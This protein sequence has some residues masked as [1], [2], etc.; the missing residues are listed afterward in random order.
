MKTKIQICFMF[1]VLI[2]SSVMGQKKTGA[3][4]LLP[5]DIANLC[6]QYNENIKT[7]V[8]NANALLTNQPRISVEPVSFEFKCDEWN[9]RLVSLNVAQMM[10]PERTAIREILQNHYGASY[11]CENLSEPP[12]ITIE[13]SDQLVKKALRAIEEYKNQAEKYAALTNLALTAGKWNTILGSQNA[14]KNN[15][16]LKDAC[17]QMA[18]I[19]L[20]TYKKKIIEEHD[21]PY[22][23]SIV[24]LYNDLN[25]LA[26][27]DYINE[28][29][30]EL[31][32]LFRFKMEIEIGVYRNSSK[33]RVSSVV[34]G[35]IPLLIDMHRQKEKGSNPLHRFSIPFKGEGLVTASGTASLKHDDGT[36]SKAENMTGEFSRK[37]KVDLN[38]CEFN[39][40][41]LCS[42]P[43][44]G[45]SENWEGQEF[46]VWTL[47]FQR[48]ANG[49]FEYLTSEKYG[50]VSIP[51]EFRFQN[52]QKIIIDDQLVILKNVD[53]SDL[54][55]EVK[56]K[57]VHDSN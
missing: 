31:E 55:L 49:N 3:I 54:K 23:G 48:F 1:F 44:L 56:Y 29:F 26:G 43:Y 39:G 46:Y 15:Q 18:K 13:L 14:E 38:L 40:K 6:E 42:Y 51:I 33:E 9:N 53:G 11:S 20:T 57:I 5:E 36:N 8:N 34:K 17:I 10:E 52:R 27:G 7:T 12:T 45:V 41:F 30:T 22:F 37:A 35:E 28:M 19:N 47:E 32:A 21:Y 2:F 25:I 4:S 24:A 50:Q 16:L